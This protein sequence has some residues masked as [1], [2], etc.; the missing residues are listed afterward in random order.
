MLPVICMFIIV[1][2]FCLALVFFG[3]MLLSAAAQRKRYIRNL[4][5]DCLVFSQIG[6]TKSDNLENIIWGVVVIV[7][8][9]TIFVYCLMYIWVV[10]CLSGKSSSLWALLGIL[11]ILLLLFSS[12]IFGI[13]KG[14][15]TFISEL[16][17]VCE[18]VRKDCQK[19]C[20]LSYGKKN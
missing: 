12:H 2:L 14:R 17:E 13:I 18:K 4:S 5:K 16:E 20:P 15:L 6:F 19:V 1:L 11:I 8:G 9:Y 7:L 3:S 10:L